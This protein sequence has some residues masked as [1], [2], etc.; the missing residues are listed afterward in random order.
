MKMRS[1]AL[2]MIGS[3]VLFAL[4]SCIPPKPDAQPS[5]AVAKPTSPDVAVAF[6][7]VL[8]PAPVMNVIVSSPRSM[9]NICRLVVA[10]AGKRNSGADAQTSGAGATESEQV[11]VTRRAIMKR[12][13]DVVAG[14]VAA[15]ISAEV[16]GSAQSQ[17]AVKRYEALGQAERL[18]LL[19]EKTGAQALLVIDT[20]GVWTIPQI[21]TI[22]SS[23]KISVRDRR[24]DQDLGRGCGGDSGNFGVEATVVGMRAKLVSL[25]K[26]DA[27]ILADIE[28]FEPL[29]E[30]LAD[31]S[32]PEFTYSPVSAER[33]ADH[34]LLNNIW[35]C[36][37]RTEIVGWEATPAWCGCANQL[38]LDEQRRI[39]GLRWSGKFEE[40]VAK[41]AESLF[42]DADGTPQC[43]A[44]ATPAPAAPAPA[45]LPAKG[46]AAKKGN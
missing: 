30:P 13:R 36:E 46:K 38:L 1:I 24:G 3:G 28:A 19:A 8:R 18:V 22:D 21:M 37:N 35:V 23:G 26:D 11:R 42:P 41:I 15:R 14:E 16:V 10:E 25:R 2:R 33:C 27:S 43:D 44:P 9:S 7:S 40:I 34:S 4:A 32:C 29:S 17:D 20:A 5:R 6:D 12:H 45:A 39:E 31:Y